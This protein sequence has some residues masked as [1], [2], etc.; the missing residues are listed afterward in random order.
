MKRAWPLWIGCVLVSGSTG[1][2][3]EDNPAA[4]FTCEPTFALSL[5]QGTVSKDVPNLCRG[6]REPDY[7]DTAQYDLRFGLLPP[8]LDLQLTPIAA[9]APSLRVA[10]DAS[11]DVAPGKYVLPVSVGLIG[12]KCTVAGSSEVADCVAQIDLQVR[13]YAPGTMPTFEVTL[14]AT[15]GGTAV[16]PDGLVDV[17]AAVTLTPRVSGAVGPVSYAWEAYDMVT[18]GLRDA[19]VHGKTTAVVTTSTV[20]AHARVFR[21]VVTDEGVEPHARVTVDRIFEGR[22]YARLGPLNRAIPTYPGTEFY[23]GLEESYTDGFEYSGP[24]STV[25]LETIGDSMSP[26]ERSAF[27]ASA[28][29]QASAPWQTVKVENGYAFG[30]LPIGVT[31]VFRL[32]WDVAV[33]RSGP[34]I[35]VVQ[36]VGYAATF[37]RGY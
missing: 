1:N 25:R 18:A 36:R 29:L 35:T 19:A 13:V 3:G 7:W 14:E 33:R 22:G 2:C 27:L 15:V 31:G 24:N 20:P 5:E 6:T 12:S 8:G 37:Y 17:G 21:L 16:G 10:L 23:P 11:M 34:D 30:A 26:M 9:G 32:V 28:V 4:Q